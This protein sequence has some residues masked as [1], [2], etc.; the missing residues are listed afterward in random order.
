MV[1]L[2][3]NEE[4]NIGRCLASLAGQTQRDFEVI[5]IDAASTDR[6]LGIV[7]ATRDRFSVPLRVEAASERLPIGAARN[8]GVR[9]AATDNI[10]FLS[11]DAEADPRWVHRALEGLRSADMVFGR[12]LHKPHRWTVGA[13]VRGLRYHFPTGRVED[14]TPYASNVGAAFRKEVLERFPF[15]PGTDAAEDVLL[16]RR[17]IAHG[18][19]STYDP[20]M[21]VEH[22]DVEGVGQELVKNV[23]EGLGC[24]RYSS[25]LGLMTP[26][27]L[28]GAALPVAVAGF[29]LFPTSIALAALLAVLW[30]PALRRAWRHRRDMDLGHIFLGLSASPFFDLVFLFH[31]LRGLVVRRLAPRPVA[32]IQEIRP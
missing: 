3:W 5:V 4:R 2:T 20:W 11:A 7:A 14:A 8:L 9:M 31:Y 25:E 26:L 18:Y 19:V 22:H 32:D 13:A 6:T 21:V 12:Q 28:W 1:V 16:A 23:R 17:A 15:E 24:G 10:A 29:V 27:L 30:A